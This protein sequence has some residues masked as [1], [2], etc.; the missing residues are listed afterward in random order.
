[1]F[2]F[3]GERERRSQGF[4]EEAKLSKLLMP[5]KMQISELKSPAREKGRGTGGGGG[6]KVRFVIFQPDH[7]HLL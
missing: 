1:M 2:P 3:P 4:R 6:K 7:T 5:L